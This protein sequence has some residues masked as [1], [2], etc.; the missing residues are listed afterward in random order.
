MCVFGISH[1]STNDSTLRLSLLRHLYRYDEELLLYD[2]RK[3]KNV[4]VLLQFC[5]WEM[6]TMKQWTFLTH[7]FWW[8]RKE[9]T[10]NCN[11]SMTSTALSTYSSS[12]SR[13]LDERK[14]AAS[15]DMK[16]ETNEFDIFPNLEFNIKLFVERAIS[17]ATEYLNNAP[18][19]LSII[20]FVLLSFWKNIFCF[21]SST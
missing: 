3:L 1:M 10:L 2:F 9:K 12:E 6:T 19:L 4:M 15:V 17:T 20:S 13:Y 16:W 7:R 18:K 11:R 5:L 14:F 8:T 21:V